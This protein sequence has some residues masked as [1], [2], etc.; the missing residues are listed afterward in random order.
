MQKLR[1]AVIGSGIA[2]MSAAWLLAHRHA[3]VLYEKNSR[4]GGHTNTVDAPR[5]DGGS[6][7]VDTGFIVYNETNYPNLTALFRH[8]GVATAPSN[9]SFSVS[10]D[11]GAL[12]YSG[13]D[14]MGLLAQ[15]ANVLKRRFWRMLRDTLRFYRRG[16]Y[17]LAEADAAELT[18]GAYLDREGY[19]P[20]FVEDHLLPMAA[21]IWSTPAGDMRAHPAV[22]FVRFCMAHGLMRLSGRPQWRTVSG[23]SREYVKRLTAPYANAVRLNT[24]VRRIHRSQ[25]GVIVE[26][27]S[28]ATERFDRVIV[29][30]HA[31]Q[32]LRLLA[33]P[34]EDEATLLSAFRYS[35]NRAVLHTDATLM[36]KRRRA[37]AS[38]NYLG[39][40]DGAGTARV[41]VT[42]W[43]NRLQNI[44]PRTPLFVTLNPLRSPRP[45]AIIAAFDYD[46]PA[47]DL[48]ALRAQ[49]RLP[50]LAG[51]RNTW[52][53]G[54]YFSSGF[55]EDA[56]VSGLNAAE[57]AGGL[58]R[59]WGAVAKDLTAE[60]G[61]RA[62]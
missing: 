20:A 59:P 8:L 41:S 24:A 4:L 27:A 39:R 49:T 55:H 7:P 53:C 61:R 18:L 51:V 40:R 21:A 47:Y 22:A 26:E 14:L 52:F 19:S 6:V 2:G 29:A 33:D 36:P 23:G 13:G 37:W 56:L 50:H 60:V 42:Y 44:D 3:V 5:H 11:D 57:A 16:P 46:H 38:W 12:E 62:A 9:M 35:R 15:P 48:Q 58:V 1:F 32:A 43:M 34:S 45:E 31:D 25:T 54:S 30:T 28:G 10:L 17:L